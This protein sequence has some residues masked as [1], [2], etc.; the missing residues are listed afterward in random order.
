MEEFNRHFHHTRNI[1]SN[2]ISLHVDLTEFL[3]SPSDSIV[4]NVTATR[5][6]FHIR[7]VLN[8][9]IQ[10]RTSSPIWIKHYLSISRAT[11]SWS[12]CISLCRFKSLDMF[13]YKKVSD[14]S[15]S[16]GEHRLTVVLW[17]GE[18]V[19][20]LYEVECYTCCSVAF[21]R[22]SLNE[23]KILK[24]GARRNTSQN[25][26]SCVHRRCPYP[27]LPVTFYILYVPFQRENSLN[28]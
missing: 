12:S 21:S 10:L 25:I 1:C 17:A 22:V 27:S 7:G 19:C 16:S 26:L 5:F 8:S 18:E 28:S 3:R 14:I 11:I 13:H 20:L 24:W 23:R 2:I 4:G 15:V 9:F 6:S